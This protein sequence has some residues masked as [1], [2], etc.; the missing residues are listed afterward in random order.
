MYGCESWT[1]KK[2]EDWRCFQIVA[3][4]KILKSP[5]DCKEIKPVNSKRHQPWIFIGRTDAKTEAPIL[6]PPVAKRWLIGKDPDAGKHWG[7]E[8]K[9]ETDDEM[10]GWHYWI[11]SLEFEQTLGNSEGQGSLAY[12]ALW[13]TKSRTAVSD[14]TKTILDFNSLSLSPIHSS[15]LR[16]LSYPQATSVRKW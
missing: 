14:W 7:Q 11:N 4:E 1:I 12:C 15:T 9:G 6:W 13:V 10:V 16:G 2:A 3:L 8:E 5:F